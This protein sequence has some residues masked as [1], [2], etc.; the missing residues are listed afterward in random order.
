M[1]LFSTNT[2]H[3]P[4]DL[5]SVTVRA[6][7]ENAAEL[8][9]M[10]EQQVQKIWHATERLYASGNHPMISLCI[11]RQGKI[12]LN[13]AIGHSRGNGPED[14]IQTPKQQALPTTPVCLFSASKVVTAMLLHYLDEQGEI[15]LLD[16]ISHYIPEYGV[17]GKR[18]ASLFHLMSHR[19][20]IPKVDGDMPPELL[21]N[22]P[23]ILKRLCAA[24]PVS[25]SGHRLAYHALSAGYILG[26]VVERV[27]GMDLRQFL[28]Q[29]ITDPLNMSCFNFGLAPEYRDQVGLSYATG[30]HPKLGTDLYL[31]HVIGGDLKLAV[32]IT[33]DPRFMDTICPAGNLYTDAEQA[34]RFFEMLLNGGELDGVRIFSP[35]TV[36][37]A[38]LETTR[39]AIDHTLLIPMRY[40][41]GPM[42]GANPI[43]LFGPMS[44]HAFGHLGFSNILC[45]ADPERDISV[46]IL[47]SG[48][49]VVGTHI[50]TLA[51][52][53]YHISAQCPKVPF[54]ERRSIFGQKFAFAEES[55]NT[56]ITA[57]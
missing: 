36:F 22:K 44:K 31:N 24:K 40:G 1:K 9:G 18:R 30:L 39:P 32:D 10:T 20:G 51:N 4:T 2:C 37:R 21:F 46:A 38:T 48:K 14:S 47:T 33:N 56:N 15:S 29:T 41:M 28:Q 53:L 42:L 27:T 35:T 49:S 26:E 54:S 43:G 19:G 7:N 52:L 23:E 45:W 13:R 50:P 8:G 17:N 12:I 5:A 11:R 55:K 16:P 25:P 57:L 6:D 34:S 3:I